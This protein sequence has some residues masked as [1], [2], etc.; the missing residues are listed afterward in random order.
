MENTPIL[1]VHGPLATVLFVLTLALCIGM[2]WFWIWTIIDCAK[3][4]K[5]DT[6]TMIAWLIC[7]ILL[8]WVGSIIYLILRRR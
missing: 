3:R 5:D 6:N 2:L 1:T 4:Y 8:S 7:I